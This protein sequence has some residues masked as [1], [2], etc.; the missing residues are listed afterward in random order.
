MIK[1]SEKITLIK[2]EKATKKEIN[3][4]FNKFNNIKCDRM[5]NE[6]NEENS[7]ILM[8]WNRNDMKNKEAKI[9]EQNNWGGLIE[10]VVQ[11]ITPVFKNMLDESNKKQEDKFKT[12]LDESN[13]KLKI[14]ILDEINP[15]FDGI[16]ND[17]KILKSDVKQLKSDVAELKSDVKMLKSFHIEEIKKYNEKNRK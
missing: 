12:M 11:A 1:E 15:R 9:H 8:E 13:K 6:E 4:V 10:A 16:E 3:Q 7:Y 5:I 2:T 17:I 14:E